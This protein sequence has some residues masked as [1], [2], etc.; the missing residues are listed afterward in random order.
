MIEKISNL[1]VIFVF[2]LLL[3]APKFNNASETLI[4]ADDIS[5]DENENI[6]ARGN[7][8]IFKENQFVISELIIY[9]QLNKKIYLPTDFTLKDEQ[10]NYFSMLSSTIFRQRSDQFIS[11][12]LL[13]DMGG[14]PSN[15]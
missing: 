5:Y 1:F 3:I 6:I 13:H 12:M 7:A 4:Y 11:S 10:N 8:K 9:D 2:F 14:P 15:S